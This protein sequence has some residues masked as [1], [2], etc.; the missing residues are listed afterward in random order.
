MSARGRWVIEWQTPDGLLRAREPWAAEVVACAGQLAGYYNQPRNRAMLTNTTALSRADVAAHYRT[1]EQAGG[2][3]FLLDCDGEL[4]GDADFRHV[5]NSDAE[6]A[7][8]IG[9]RSRQGQGLGGRFGLMLH[10]FAFE[11]MH[12]QRLYA[13][14]IP[15]N[16]AS[17][18]LF[19]KLGHEVDSSPAARRYADE[20]SDV[21][22]SVGRHRFGEVRETARPALTFRERGATR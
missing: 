10:A 11:V 8:L 17:L 13:A 21:T 4:V 5:T 19:E 20:P 7:I 15:G 12:L 2:R 16:H 14:I 22:T 6:M 3:P 1:L 18:R 9:D